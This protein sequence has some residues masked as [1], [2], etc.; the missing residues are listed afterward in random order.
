VL[1][2]II[3]A[4]KIANIPAVEYACSIDL[5]AYG[6]QL[7]DIIYPSSSG[8]LNNPDLAHVFKFSDV[9]PANTNRI[10]ATNKSRLLVTLKAIDGALVANMYQL[11]MT[12]P[13]SVFS[14][15]KDT[16]KKEIVVSLNCCDA[17]V[18]ADYM[19]V[20]NT[21][22]IYITKS[23]PSYP[24]TYVIKEKTTTKYNNKIYPY[25]VLEYR[26]NETADIPS[27]FAKRKFE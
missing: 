26:A 27:W 9:D 18:P 5:P 22:Y 17:T 8:Y 16:A 2:N 10:S 24:L 7:Y 15:K 11:I 4:S 1:N 25:V 14:I 12:I 13:V 6:Y 20:S 3:D 19:G 21:A 23:T